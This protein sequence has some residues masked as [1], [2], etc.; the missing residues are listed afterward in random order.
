MRFHAALA[1]ALL[2][3]VQLHAHHSGI[4]FD[5]MKQVTLKGTVRSSSSRT[6]T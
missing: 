6:R 3:G 1:I 5:P 4:M 2:L